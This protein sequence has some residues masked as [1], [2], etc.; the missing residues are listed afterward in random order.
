MTA[1]Q[2]RQLVI[3]ALD[4]TG[5]WDQARVSREYLRLVR[6]GTLKSEKEAARGIH[7]PTDLPPGW[8]LYLTQG[9]LSRLTY[10]ESGQESVTFIE[11]LL[12][13]V[14]VDPEKVVDIL[15]FGC[16]VGRIARWWS[17]EKS[18]SGCD[19][20]P[21]LVTWCQHHIPN[22]TFSLNGLAPPTNYPDNSFD[23]LYSQSVLTHLPP[24]L[25]VAWMAEWRRLVRPGGL[26]LATTLGPV[27]LWD[28]EIQKKALLQNGSLSL[29]SERAG[30]NL[31]AVYN[32]S[33]DV[34]NRVGKGLEQIYYGEYGMPQ[35]HQDVNLFRVP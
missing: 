9:T 28:N 4:R 3:R 22:G 14:G 32:T 34:A 1:E 20:N 13:E 18:L 23:L 30:E 27:H 12:G 8:L 35:S 31:C 10:H 7:A 5:L 15:D 11:T 16:G 26:I 17:A 33:D 24:E 2:L 29:A 6:T 19:Y 21:K 25:Q